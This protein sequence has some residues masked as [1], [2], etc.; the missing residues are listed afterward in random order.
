MASKKQELPEAKV[1]EENTDDKPVIP[2]LGYEVCSFRHGPANSDI[3]VSEV[4]LLIP[5]PI[6]GARVA[7]R[8]KSKRALDELVGVLLE[9]RNE[10]WPEENK[11]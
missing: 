10:V 8:L 11:G 2:G 7:L 6:E 9:Y 5:L 3:P 4:H 1:I